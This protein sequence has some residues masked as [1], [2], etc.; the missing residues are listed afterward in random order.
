MDVLAA[1]DAECNAPCPH[2]GAKMCGGTERIS[3]YELTVIGQLPAVDPSVD[4]PV[5]PVVDP[6]DP[7]GLLD[8]DDDGLDGLLDDDG[9]LVCVLIPEEC[10][11]R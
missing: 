1:D 5:D 9:P 6:S 11:S 7:E 4:P 3:I 8:G 10:N 2:D